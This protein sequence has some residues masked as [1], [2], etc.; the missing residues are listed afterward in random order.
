MFGFLKLCY[1]FVLAIEI[2]PCDAAEAIVMPT[3]NSSR[4]P[5]GFTQDWGKACGKYRSSC[6]E[7]FCKKGG[8]K[9][10]LAQAFFSEF[11]EISKNTF[12]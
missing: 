8:L 10:T 1:F 5:A 6:P 2:Q 3:T 9:N 7:V 12:F 4:S 11:C